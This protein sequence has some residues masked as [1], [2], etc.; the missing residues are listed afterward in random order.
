M[1][2]RCD[3]LALHFLLEMQCVAALLKDVRLKG[4]L[5][6][7]GVFDGPFEV[8]EDPKIHVFA[9]H[10]HLVLGMIGGG[11]KRFS[12][13]ASQVNFEKNCV[14]QTDGLCDIGLCDIKVFSH[15]GKIV[16]VEFYNYK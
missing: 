8:A 16:R 3:D 11:K 12:C 1:H 13:P 7:P 10:Q 15:R 9:Q 5:Q 6:P 14:E 2:L 4:L